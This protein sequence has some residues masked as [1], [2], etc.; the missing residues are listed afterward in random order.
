MIDVDGWCRRLLADK[1]LSAYAKLVGVWFA[2]CR[3][4]MRDCPW[5]CECGSPDE[6][7]CECLSYSDIAASTGISRTTVRRAL[8]QL[9]EGGWLRRRVM[10]P[11]GRNRGDAYRLAEPNPVA[12]HVEAAS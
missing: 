6:S 5:G 11:E 4:P 9:V 10:P 2:V 12:E 8:P 7:R 1:N 3:E